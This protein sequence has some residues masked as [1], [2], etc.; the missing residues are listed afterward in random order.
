MNKNKLAAQLVIDEGLKPKVYKD[1]LGIETIGVGRNLRDKGL[2]PLEIQFLLA[3]DIDD[4]CRDLDRSLP[5]WRVMNE[6][7]Q[8][9]L[10]NMCFNMGI[11]RLLGF[12]KALAA[13]KEERWSDAATEMR[14]SK[15]AEQV[16]D[17][18]KR[19]AKLMERGEE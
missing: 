9:V 8:N 4:V 13:M 6:T 15:W 19:L 17:R 7:R 11:A 10:A 14:S 12:K 5:W 2:S 3:N 1:S 16:G 18:A